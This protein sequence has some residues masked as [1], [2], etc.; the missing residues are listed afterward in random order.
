MFKKLI[1]NIVKKELLKEYVNT[2]A[3]V[4]A[5]IEVLYENNLVT[6]TKFNRLCEKYKDAL[7][8]VVEH[9]HKVNLKEEN[10]EISN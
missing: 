7:N 4:L 9:T 6:G 1:N 5:T 8:V 2:R 3:E 10:N